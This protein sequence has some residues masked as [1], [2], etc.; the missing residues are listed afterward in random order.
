MRYED[1]WSVAKDERDL[2]SLRRPSRRLNND[3]W[4]LPKEQRY[5][6]VKAKVTRP[7][8]R[9]ALLFSSEWEK[10][11][12]VHLMLANKWDSRAAFY[13]RMLELLND[14]SEEE[15]ADMIR[16]FF[17]LIGGNK[18]TLRSD[19]LWKDFWNNRSACIAHARQQ[20]TVTVTVDEQ[21][22]FEKLERLNAK[23]R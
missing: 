15:V 1:D 8:A 4:D 5:P 22:Q 23:K 16:S 18:I 14:Y 12:E 13:T 6:P 20:S 21:E 17:A 19:V 2:P 9:L 10:A 11:R 7:T 3:Q